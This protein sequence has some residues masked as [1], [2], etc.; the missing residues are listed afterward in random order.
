M[1]M[2]GGLFFLGNDAAIAR[3]KPTRRPRTSAIP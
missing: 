2:I 1:S 3:H